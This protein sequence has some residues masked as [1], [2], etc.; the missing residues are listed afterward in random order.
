MRDQII[1]TKCEVID[2]GP[3]QY[4]GLWSSFVES[5][6]TQC[7]KYNFFLSSSEEKKSS[8]KERYWL[9]TIKRSQNPIF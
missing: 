2:D 5:N 9:S 7:N 4:K 1:I 6:L 3:Y 8:E